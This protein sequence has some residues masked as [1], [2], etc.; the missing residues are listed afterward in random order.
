MPGLPRGTLE[1]GADDEAVTERLR[2][3]GYVR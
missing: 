2:A 3:L 1:G